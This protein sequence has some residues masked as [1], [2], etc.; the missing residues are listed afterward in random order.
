M[1]CSVCDS[2]NLREFDSEIIIHIDEG[3]D[4]L[5]KSNALVFPKITICM[6]S[7]F[8]QGQIKEDDF[9]PSRPMSRHETGP[10][11][12]SVLSDLEKIHIS[13]I[14]NSALRRRGRMLTFFPIHFCPCS[15]RAV[16]QPTFR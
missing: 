7:G 12:E 2:L 16:L 8:M 3:I 10:L 14:S 6:D 5:T 11:T 4:D 1:S 9:S 15:G 13:L